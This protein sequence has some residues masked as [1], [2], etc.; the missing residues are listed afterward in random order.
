MREVWKKQKKKKKCL[1]PQRWSCSAVTVTPPLYGAWGP[2]CQSSAAGFK[3]HFQKQ[4]ADTR[5]QPK[6]E[7]QPSPGPGQAGPGAAQTRTRLRQKQNTRTHNTQSVWEC[8]K[9]CVSVT[10]STLQ[11]NN[12]EENRMVS[13]RKCIFHYIFPKNVVK[14]II[15]AFLNAGTSAVIPAADTRS[16]RIDYCSYHHWSVN[17]SASRK[18]HSACAFVHKWELFCNSVICCLIP[19]YNRSKNLQSRGQEVGRSGGRTSRNPE[20][21]NNL[22]KP[23]WFISLN[24]LKTFF[25]IIFHSNTQT[26]LY[27][28]KNMQ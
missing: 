2:A 21:N 26:K 15:G 10:Q 9:S 22:E 25:Y 16:H 11:C 23:D 20:I 8:N 28:C 5:A 12:S 1:A 7:P 18:C 19:N 27:V 3:A 4:A 13:S 6:A 24:N 14:Y 17:S